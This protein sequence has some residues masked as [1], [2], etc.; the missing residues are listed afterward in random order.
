MYLYK[1]KE[2][3]G[4]IRWTGV[5]DVYLTVD[6]YLDN[7]DRPYNRSVSIYTRGMQDSASE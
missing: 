5:V 2:S 6:K 1:D 4:V 3:A 7:V